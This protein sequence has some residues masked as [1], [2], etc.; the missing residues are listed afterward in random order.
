MPP[1][2]REGIA[3][4]P[5]EELLNIIR[6]LRTSF[7]TTTFASDHV[8]GEYLPDNE[9]TAGMVPTG[10]SRMGKQLDVR[11]WEVIQKEI[12]DCHE[13]S[14]LYGLRGCSKVSF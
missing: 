1:T 13:S 10:R 6:P 9:D 5:P 3:M 7:A 8:H 14:Q 12:M 4:I 2:S 11:I